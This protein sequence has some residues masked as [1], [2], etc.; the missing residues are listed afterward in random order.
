M[1]K[2]TLETNTIRI[3]SLSDAFTVLQYI[4][5]IPAMEESQHGITLVLE[6]QY[7]L[8]TVFI[9]PLSLYLSLMFM[10]AHLQMLFKYRR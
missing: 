6:L 9:T 4:T 8:P 2:T 10:L 5:E 7:C 3:T 1:K